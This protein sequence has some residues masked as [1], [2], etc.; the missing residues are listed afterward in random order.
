M[1]ADILENPTLGPREIGINYRK[2]GDGIGMEPTVS[3]AIDD[4]D[5]MDWLERSITSIRR[6]LADQGL[7]IQDLDSGY[8]R[9]V[10][11]I[12]D[13]HEAIESYRLDN[14][15]R[16]NR[17]V[18]AITLISGRVDSTLGKME[19]NMGETTKLMKTQLNEV[20][21]KVEV[22]EDQVNY[23]RGYVEEVNTGVAKIESMLQEYINRKPWWQF[24]KD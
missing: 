12:G 11:R 20:S 8:G 9:I 5:R 17:Q 10:S 2:T 6:V 4:R 23:L 14:I 7:H 19:A 21:A 24:W 15:D 18:E 16:S 22:I 3:R 1:G 13:I